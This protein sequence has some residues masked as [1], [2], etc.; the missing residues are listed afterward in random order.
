MRKKRTSEV[1]TNAKNTVKEVSKDLKDKM[2]AP[3]VEKAKETV[4][5]AAQKTETTV[6]AATKTAK[7]TTK[8]VKE[9]TKE[10]TKAVKETTKAVKE[11][12]RTRVGA[13]NLEIFETN[14]TV[15]AVKKA[16]KNDA[17]EKGLAGSIV[18][19]LNAE[20]RAAYYTV[21]GVGSE[22]YK[23]DLTAL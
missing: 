13:V 15:D 3:V 6:K 2:N 10:A 20:E 18:I 5:E 16:V 14:V 4:K 23:V 7:A 1:K 12:A 11:T 19:Y 9:T 8:A 17:A 22:D 21:D